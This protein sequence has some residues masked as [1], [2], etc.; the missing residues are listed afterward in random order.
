[1]FWPLVVVL[2]AK[3]PVTHAL[4]Y[5]FLSHSSIFF[6]RS[7]SVYCLCRRP[8]AV[9]RC[10][11]SLQLAPVVRTRPSDPTTGRR[12]REWVEREN[13]I[14]LL[15]DKE[16]NHIDST[17]SH[18]KFFKSISISGWAAKYGGS[19]HLIIETT[20]FVLFCLSKSPLLSQCCLTYTSCLIFICSL[21]H[22]GNNFQLGGDFK[23][24]SCQMGDVI[25]PAYPGSNPGS[26]V[27]QKHLP[28][29][30]S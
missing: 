16:K 27:C 9:P 19:L 14:M 23:M 12:A 2:C 25:P 15:R 22:K 3:R 18:I 29:K 26:L 10:H 8:L 28:R 20:F 5:Y 30:T 4:H 11:S 21:G 17:T 24:F 1:M 7:H 6:L 13:H